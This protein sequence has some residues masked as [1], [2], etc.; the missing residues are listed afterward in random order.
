MMGQGPPRPGLGAVELAPS[1][2]SAWADAVLAAALFA[3]DPAGTAG[4]ALRALPGPVRDGWLAL[5]RSLLPA[6]CPRSKIPL[7]VS[8]SR[9]LGGLDLAAT[10]RLGRPI[11]ERGLLAQADGGVV[12]LAMAERLTGTTTAHLTAVLDAGEVVLERD[13]IAA[14]S[15]SRLGVIALD[16]GVGEDERLPEPLRDR[17]A[18]HLDLARFGIHDTEVAIPWGM[19]EIEDARARV[20][21]VVIGDAFVEILCGAALALG[22]AS[23]RGSL[24]AI[25]VARLA[26][27]LVGRDQV[28]EEDVA[29]A[30]RLVLAPRA[31][32]LPASEPAPEEEPPPEPPPPEPPEEGQNQDEQ[33]IPDQPLEDM[34]LE[35]AQAAMPKDLL[36]QLRA[37]VERRSRTRSQ[38]K[39]GA[40]QHASLRGRPIGARPGD[41]GPG[42]R[43]NVVET[44]RAAA[45][46]QVIR[47]RETQARGLT[48]KRVEVRK[49]DFRVTRFKQRTQTSVIFSV[50]ASGSAALQR[51]AEA[52]GAVEQVLVDCYVRRDHVA[53][54]AF[55]GTAAQLLLSPTR[56]LLRVRRNLADLAG[57]GTTPLAAGIDAA[58]GLGLEARRRGQTP[59]IVL[60]TDGRANIARDGREGRSAAE[61]D[62]LAGARA[63]REAGVRAIFLDTSPRPQA[64]AQA[65]AAAMGARYVPLPY[66]D[67]ARICREVQAVVDSP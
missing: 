54:I 26:A 40:E 37:G 45:P 56:S 52:K 5:A 10:L 1:Q 63:V 29:A 8:E 42:V 39:A 46:W 64:K 55:R 41:L 57:G 9:L 3:V 28:A 53:L 35:A 48:P 65:L 22:I 60:M 32:R 36:D 14:R 18:F 11:A 67:A 33:D 61:A 19:A 12:E 17:L 23:L 50:D 49:D 59:L 15:D 30:A 51:L 38:G 24:L 66:V 25:R 4:V 6:D 2:D 34:V 31:T 43:M 62:A 7:H 27:A 16:E 13:G 44:L 58:L 21:A 20:P 47:R